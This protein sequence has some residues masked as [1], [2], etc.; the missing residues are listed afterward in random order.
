VADEWEL[1]NLTADPEE[2]HNLDATGASGLALR[3]LLESER[4]VKRVAPRLDNSI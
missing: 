4:D 3:R 1:Y 2:R